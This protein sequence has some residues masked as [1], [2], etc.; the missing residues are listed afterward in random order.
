M[1]KS[2]AILLT[3]YALDILPLGDAL[4]SIDEQ[5]EALVSNINKELE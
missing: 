3:Y 1:I 2:N 4:S 5:P